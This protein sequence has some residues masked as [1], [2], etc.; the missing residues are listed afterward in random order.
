[1]CRKVLH[2]VV[3]V[4]N[5][6]YLLIVPLS[7]LPFSA[8]RRV[9]TALANDLSFYLSG[10]IFVDPFPSKYLEIDLITVVAHDQSKVVLRLPQRGVVKFAGLEIPRKGRIDKI[11]FD[12][13]GGD[14]TWRECEKGHHLLS[15]PYIPERKFCMMC[16]SKLSTSS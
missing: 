12:V 16:L 2:N 10:I 14:C 8:D 15:R 6:V 1:M 5:S 7:N 11:N 4:P 13:Y 9:Y 3:G